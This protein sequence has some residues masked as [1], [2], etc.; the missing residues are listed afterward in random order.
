MARFHPPTLHFAFFY[1][2]IA[3]TTNPRLLLAS[4]D[5]EFSIIDSDANLFHQDYSPPA[6][7]PPPPH[8]PS[9]SCTDDLGGVGTLDATCKIVADTNLTSDV[10]IEGKG[11]FYILPGFRQLLVDFSW[12][13]RAHGPNAS[14]LDGSA[15]NTTALAGKPPAQTSGTPQGIEGRVGATEDVARV[16]WWMRRSFRRTCGAATPTLG[17]RCSIRVVLGAEGVDE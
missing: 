1:I 4:D 3:L 6:P 11:N 2:L 5:D 15:V 10:Y 13:F 16:V 8:P 12:G 9:V 7:P 17:R 14:F